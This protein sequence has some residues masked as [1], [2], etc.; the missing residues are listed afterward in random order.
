MNRYLATDR[1]L[2]KPM[3]ILWK[4]L[5]KSCCRARQLMKFSECKPSSI[6]DYRYED[7]EI[8]RYQCHPDIKGIDFE[9]KLQETALQLPALTIVDSNAL[10]QPRR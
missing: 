3:W 10:R 6:F 5:A 4:R 7:F 8:E 9:L 1:V 2:G